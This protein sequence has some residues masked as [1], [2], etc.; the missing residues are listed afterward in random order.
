MAW[1]LNGTYFEACNCD[2]AC[3]C[4]ITSLQMPATHERCNAMLAFH[5]DDGEIEGFRSTT[6]MSS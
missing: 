1:R 5:V 4:T 2:V 6:S 3:P